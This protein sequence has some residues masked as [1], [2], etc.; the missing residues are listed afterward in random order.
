MENKKCE[1]KILLS[2]IIVAIGMFVLG[3]STGR[4]FQNF[5]FWKNHLVGP[6]EDCKED[7]QFET[8]KELEQFILVSLKDDLDLTDKQVSDITPCIET[9][10]KECFEVKRSSK[11]LI[12]KSLFSC[13]KKIMMF[14]SDDQKR[15][16]MKMTSGRRKTDFLDS[17]A[18]NKKK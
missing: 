2:F 13:R 12:E 1:K 16:F 8:V 10:L 11:I 4:I 6:D 3:F 15:V 14:L 18:P 7:F 5:A 17:V 9:M